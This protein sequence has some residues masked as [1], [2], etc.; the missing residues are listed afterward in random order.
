MLF[1]DN[2]ALAMPTDEVLQKLIDHFANASTDG[3]LTFSVNKDENHSQR[4]MHPYRRL[5]PR[6]GRRLRL[7]WV[8]HQ[9][10]PVLLYR[11]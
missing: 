3:G 9:R 6:G 5:Y 1:V 2:A 4:T 7:T 10:K 8:H 11:A